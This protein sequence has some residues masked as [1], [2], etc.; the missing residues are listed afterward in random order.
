[1][2][3]I[4]YYPSAVLEHSSDADVSRFADFFKLYGI[5][6]PLIDR[7]GTACIP[8]AVCS[9]FPIPELRPFNASYED[10]CNAR[11]TEI[12]ASAERMGVNIY[13]S[14]SG[15][16]D[17]TLVLVS[18]LKNAT[19][20]QKERIVVMLTEESIRENPRFWAEHIHGKLHVRSAVLFSYHL[21]TKD[22]M[23]DGECNDQLFGS[24]VA[25]KFISMFGFEALNGAYDRGRQHALINANMQ[26]KDATDFYVDLFER[27]AA[28]APADVSTNFLFL[29]WINYAFLWQGVYFRKL[30]YVAPRQA[31]QITAAYADLRF[32]HFFSTP[33]FQLWSLN[34][35]DKRI[36]DTWESY[37]WP[38][39]DIIYEYTKDAEY[40]DT[41]T[42]RG[43]QR[44]LFMQQ[45]SYH[46]I[47]EEFN[48]HEEL[49]PATYYAAKNNFD[50]KTS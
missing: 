28:A 4:Y 45:H 22:I 5:G 31:P 6:T 11:A 36:K 46:F 35:P 23:L 47:D 16:I 14:W 27:T 43:S 39:K 50:I 33:E 25:R 29:W 32:L 30:A 40:R 19:A 38:A 44:A 34:N 3:L 15:G 18:L 20:G 9:L 10:V 48:F 42:K 21:G 26:K 24:D 37:K 2:R 8:V 41:K 17:S 12:L 1:M 49:Q 7:T 13:V